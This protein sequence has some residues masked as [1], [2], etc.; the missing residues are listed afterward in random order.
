MAGSE[1]PDS[2]TGAHGAR[3]EGGSV[4][5]GFFTVCSLSPVP[6]AGPSL[7][8]PSGTEGLAALCRESPFRPGFMGEPG[9]RSLLHSHT[10]FV[11]HPC[12]SHGS[13]P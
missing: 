12:S 9:S 11:S 2:V 5:P 3:G 7:G 8:L 13:S 1:A 6:R 4:S 10:F